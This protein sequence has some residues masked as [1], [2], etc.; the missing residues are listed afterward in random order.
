MFP[1]QEALGLHFFTPVKMLVGT[2]PTKTFG[3]KNNVLQIFPPTYSNKND[4]LI[5]NNSLN[6]HYA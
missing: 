5:I 3:K 1:M 6:Y 4:T 2:M